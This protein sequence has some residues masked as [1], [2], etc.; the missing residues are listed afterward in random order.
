MGAAATKADAKAATEHDRRARTLA[1]A[2]VFSAVAA[3]VFLLTVV[4]LYQGVWLLLTGLAALVV[5]GVGAW[6]FVSRRGVPR[7]IGAA[8]AVAA[9]I[10]VI[11]LYTGDG[12]WFDSVI[13]VALW[14]LA[15]ACGRSALRIDAAR[16]A[17]ALESVPAPPLRHPV[18]IMNPKSG[19]GKVGR[20]G[21]VEKAGALGAE[22][23]VLDTSQP[24]DVEGIARRAVAEGADLLGVAGG[25]G[26]QALVA[27]VAAEHDLP[28][29]VISAGTRNHFAMDLGLDRDDPSTCLDA[30]RDGEELRIDLGDLAGRPF[31]NTASFG[32]YAQIVQN[33]EYRDSKSGTM[34]NELPDLLTGDEGAEALRAE[35]DGDRLP[36]PQV[37]LVTNNPY[38][39]TE[40]LGGGRRPRLDR[41]VL[42]VV[43]VHVEGSIDAAQLAVLGTSSRSVTV[44]TAHE[45]RVDAEAGTIPVAVDGE[46][47]NLEP[48]VV[49]T[50]R[51]GVLRVRVPRDRPGAVPEPVKVDWRTVGALA[52]GR[53]GTDP[54]R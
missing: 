45:V 52:V 32:A 16:R 25:D 42:G 11:V 18:L 50:I 23:V 51:P 43:A 14:A 29:L 33:P 34:L 48:P 36:R 3:V 27:S 21:L 30:L 7:W 24:Q 4:L 35:A 2:A 47:L 8:V 41:G 15:L 40:T 20:F 39:E 46:A 44:R 9:P 1:Q 19:G 49:C 12:F 10:T 13:V 22:V 5:A 26:T 17:A 37:L 31:V 54:R 53:T 28:F 38:G 6:W